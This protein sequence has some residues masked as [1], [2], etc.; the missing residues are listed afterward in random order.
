MTKFRDDVVLSNSSSKIR[1][2]FF[3]VAK[4]DNLRLSELDY[5]FPTEVSFSTLSCAGFP[6]V[7]IAVASSTTWSPVRKKPRSSG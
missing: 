2:P 5:F 1:S 4:L 6:L 3:H 7:L